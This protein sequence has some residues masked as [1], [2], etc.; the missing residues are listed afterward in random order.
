MT[1]NADSGAS[2]VRCLER[3]LQAMNEAVA[4]TAVDGP[5]V[6]I[7]YIAEFLD[8][9]DGVDERL[10]ADHPTDWLSRWAVIQMSPID[11]SG[12]P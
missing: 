10:A 8:M 7:A 2:V 6:A 9:T 4:M 1:P 11:G 5:V 3:A 12:T